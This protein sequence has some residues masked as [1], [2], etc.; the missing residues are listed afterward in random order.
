MSSP[1]GTNI[2]ELTLP[3]PAF[4]PVWSPDGG[5][6]LVSVFGPQG[7][8]PATVDPDGR[9]FRLLAVPDLS[10]GTNVYCRSWSPDGARLACQ[11]INYSGDNA[12][13]GL[14]TIRSADG[15]KPKRLTTNPYPPQDDFGGGDL[16]GDFSPDGTQIVFMRARPEAGPELSQSGALF[17]VRTDGRG[18]RQITPYGLPNSHE[19]GVARWA[20]DGA[21]I[22]CS[23][24]D[25]KLYVL[26]PDGEGLR[27]IAL[28]IPGSG[29]Y[30]FTPDWSPD[31]Q[32]LIFAL[33]R[34]DTGR[35]DL[36][37]ARRTGAHLR[38]VTDS[39][40]DE[41]FP[42]WASQ[43]PRR[44]RPAARTVTRPEP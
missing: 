25:G 38:R 43:V 18:L 44:A 2:R 41:V 40:D 33:F 19:E 32:N 24:D 31:G 23:G 34:E 5:K 30:A 42:T 27:Q 9:H 6:L 37:T 26:R 1:R 15:A 4:V 11:L 12:G 28:Q 20:P 14:Y 17:V 35:V 10:E 22:L 21:R 39:A 16:A 36:F 7:V 29:Y 8:G 13:D 3:Y